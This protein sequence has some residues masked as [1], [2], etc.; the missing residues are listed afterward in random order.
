M[1][2][3]SLLQPFIHVHLNPP[4]AWA[5][6]VQ[7]GG[8]GQGAKPGVRVDLEAV[9]FHFFVTSSL[10]PSCWRR[11]R[12][13]FQTIYRPVPWSIHSPSGAHL[14]NG[15]PASLR[16]GPWGHPPSSHSVCHARDM[17]DKVRLFYQWEPAPAGAWTQGLWVC[18][19]WLFHGS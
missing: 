9:V 4:Q 18:A 11:F 13:C 12:G 10:W 16:M 8:R 6:G 3:G 1:Y 2:M 17:W 15:L 19:L 5:G 14:P 7:C